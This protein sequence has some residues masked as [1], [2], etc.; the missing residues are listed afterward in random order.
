MVISVCIPADGNILV[1]YKFKQLLKK[2]KNP[3]AILPSNNH[4]GQLRR[5]RKEISVDSPCHPSPVQPPGWP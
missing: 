3:S 2:R 1:G 5:V 4:L